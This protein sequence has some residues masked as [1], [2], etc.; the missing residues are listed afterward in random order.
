VALLLPFDGVSPRVAADAFLAPNAVIVGNVTVGPEASIWFG[1]V[2]RGDHPDFGVE[3]GPRTSI[4]DNC[5]VH[6]GDWQPT[7]IGADVTVGHGAKMESCTVEDGSV[8]GMGAVILQE[9]II[10][11]GSLVA[12]GS[13]VLEGSRIPPG[14]LVAGVPAR[15]K[16]SLGGSSW[17]F[18]RRSG[19]HYVELSRRYL[20]QGIGRSNPAMEEATHCDLCGGPVLERHCKILCLACGYQRDCSDP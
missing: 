6:V 13:V 18:V 5:V 10:G 15:V 7:Y 16:K 2:L 3:V 19:T 4:Q 9:A 17:E 11:A 1:A 8:I 12:A 14:S 20:A